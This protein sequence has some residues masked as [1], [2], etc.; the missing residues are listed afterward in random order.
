MTNIK[1]STGTNIPKKLSFSVTT[2]CLNK[3]YRLDETTQMTS[4]NQ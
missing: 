1:I 3:V 2:Q 4:F